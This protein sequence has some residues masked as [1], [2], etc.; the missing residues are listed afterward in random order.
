MNFFEDYIKGKLA[1]GGCLLSAIVIILVIFAVISCIKDFFSPSDG[2]KTV[3]KIIF[4]IGS[5]FIIWNEFK[6]TK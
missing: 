1:L 2:I 3:A 5:I 6:K 4:V